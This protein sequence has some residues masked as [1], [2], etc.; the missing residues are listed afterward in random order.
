VL[1]AGTLYLASEEDVAL[2]GDAQAHLL[3]R[4]SGPL[5]Q[6]L[7]AIAAGGVLSLAPLSAAV[8]ADV[9]LPAMLPSDWRCGLGDTTP[10][11]VHCTTMSVLLQ[12]ALETMY[13]YWALS[14][15][16]GRC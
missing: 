4:A 16:Q 2:L 3:L 6:R 15:Q 8:L 14:C 13:V 5:Q 9:F 12:V 7:A 11:A 1:C 10:S